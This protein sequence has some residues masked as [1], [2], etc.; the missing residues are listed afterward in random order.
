[1]LISG[2]QKTS[3]IDYPGKICTILFTRGCNF[4][5]GFCHNPELVNKDKYIPII[6][7]EEILQF[8]KR[9]KDLIEAITITGGEPTLHSDLPNF[10]KQVKDMGYLIKLDSN[11]TNPEMLKEILSKN[12]IDFVA[13]DIKNS[14]SK[15]QETVNRKL[16]IEK[17]K[18]SI[19]LIIDSNINHE[20]RTTLVPIIHT[21]EDVLNMTKIIKG[22]QTYVL[23]NFKSTKT[24]DPA[25]TKSRSFTQKEMLEFKKIAKSQIKDVKIR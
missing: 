4:S 17:I 23:Q 24:V 16:N 7:N 9:R 5:C 21:K 3:L 22:C 1:M 10:I 13:M 2:I 6:P 20:F 25:F 18:K 15:Y 14:F 11:G 12:L 19:K 8:L